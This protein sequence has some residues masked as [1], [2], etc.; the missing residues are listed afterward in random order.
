MY[1]KGF[2]PKTV[3]LKVTTFNIMT[4]YAILAIYLLPKNFRTE[5]EQIKPGYC[6]FI[7]RTSIFCVSIIHD[8]VDLMT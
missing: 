8:D 3:A 1:V 6:L 2:L 5:Y 7:K 4:F